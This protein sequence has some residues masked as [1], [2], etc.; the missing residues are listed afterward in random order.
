MIFTSLV[1]THS[2]RRFQEA[3]AVPSSSSSFLG[4]SFLLSSPLKKSILFF[5]SLFHELSRSIPF[6]FLIETCFNA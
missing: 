3:E 5:F 2:P 6:V 4:E 1:D